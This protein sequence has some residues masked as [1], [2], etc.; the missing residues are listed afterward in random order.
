MFSNS[1]FQL[2][3]HDISSIKFKETRVISFLLG[4]YVGSQNY[5]IDAKKQNP[6]G[7][8]FTLKKIFLVVSNSEEST[9]HS[10]LSRNFIM[11]INKIMFFNMNSV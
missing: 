11:H 3:D 5:G 2:L 1:L 8:N 4:S 10:P 6:E 9:Q 7:N